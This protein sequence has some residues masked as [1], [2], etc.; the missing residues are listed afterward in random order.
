MATHSS[1]LAGETHGHSSPAD[2]SP[3]GCRVGHKKATNTVRDKYEWRHT[4]THHT[5]RVG[6]EGD[7]SVNHNESR[8]Y[9][10]QNLY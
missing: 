9:Y 4:H 5:V 8:K 1:I 7:C 3:W 10:Q 2:Y 6:G